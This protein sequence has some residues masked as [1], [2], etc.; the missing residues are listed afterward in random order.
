MFFGNESPKRTSVAG[1]FGCAWQSREVFVCP[2]RS[3]LGSDEPGIR[4][5]MSTETWCLCAGSDVNDTLSDGRKAV[6]LQLLIPAW[7]TVCCSIVPTAVPQKAREPFADH[8]TAR[9]WVCEHLC[10]LWSFPRL[11]A[12]RQDFDPRCAVRFPHSGA[13]LMLA[14]LP[15]GGSRAG[16]TEWRV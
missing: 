12:P 2:R 11:P 16:A 1:V 8:P 10:R 6:C 5:P 7:N 14:F 15:W 3:G 9:P 13:D 4:Y